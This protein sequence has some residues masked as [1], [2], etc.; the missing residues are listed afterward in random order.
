[1]LLTGDQY[2]D[3]SKSVER[4][5]LAINQT[6]NRER[7]RKSNEVRN[8]LNLKSKFS[9]AD[10]VGDIIVKLTRPELRQLHTLYLTKVSALTSVVI[11]GYE[12]RISKT[13]T[14]EAKELYKKYID[15]AQKSMAEYGKL[16]KQIEKEIK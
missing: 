9:G 13:S 4:M 8:F 1:M 16:L 12:D 11:P 2:K 6:T 5:L 14:Q 15:K 10:I 7:R 3:I